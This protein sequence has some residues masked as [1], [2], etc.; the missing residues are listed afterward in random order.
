VHPKDRAAIEQLRRNG[1][2][3]SIVTGRL[4]SGTRAIARSLG[5]DG[6]VGC[7]DGSHIVCVRDDQHLVSHTIAAPGAERLRHWLLESGAVSYLLAYDSVVH[8]AGGLA[9]LRYLTSWTRQLRVVGD[10][11]DAPNFVGR[12]AP[13]AVVSLGREEQIRSVQARILGEGADHLQAA[14]FSLSPAGLRGMWGMVVRASGPSKAT[15]FE[16]IAQHYGASR[17]ETFAVGDWWNDV[18]MLKA[19]GRSF[20]MAQAPRQVAAAATDRLKA[21]DRTGGGIAE[22]ARRAGL[23]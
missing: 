3:V 13:M 12:F 11:L 2:Q 6:P 20:A 15:A 7:V 14:A 22:A 19:A 5:L 10:V 4:Y 18:P 9:Y 1:V 16:W 23:L 21:D 8:D 17:S